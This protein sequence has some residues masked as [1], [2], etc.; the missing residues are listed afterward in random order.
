MLI[1][2]RNI[3]QVLVLLSIVVVL[4]LS[5]QAQEGGNLELEAD[6][7][8]YNYK[9]GSSIYRGNVVVERGTMHLTGDQVKIFTANN[10]TRRIL[11][12]GSPATY[13]NRLSEQSFIFIK[14]GKIDYDNVKQL[15]RLYDN[16][17]IDYD[18]KI[19]RG[20]YVVYNLKTKLIKVPKSKKRVRLTIP[21]DVGA[22]IQ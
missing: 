5:A 9:D 8:E 16:T 21:E 4:A 14:A 10:K 1:L 6:D 17:V 13:K 18:G 15:M 20:D 2:S 12:E 22:D 7:V 3:L 19:L 11:A